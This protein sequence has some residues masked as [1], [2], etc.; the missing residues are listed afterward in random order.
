M[1][2]F[3]FSRWWNNVFQS[4]RT[5]YTPTESVKEFPL[6]NLLTIFWISSHCKNFF[7]GLVGVC[8][9]LSWVLSLCL[10]RNRLHSFLSPCSQPEVANPLNPFVHRIIGACFTVRENCGACSLSEKTLNCPRPSGSS[11]IRRASL[12]AQEGDTSSQFQDY[13]LSHSG[14]SELTGPC[15]LRLPKWEDKWCRSSFSPFWSPANMLALRRTLKRQSCMVDNIL[16]ER[17]RNSWGGG[18]SDGFSIAAGIESVA[19]QR[20]ESRPP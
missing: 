6:I 16:S 2:I 10:N 17:V 19:H 4:G 5:I 1:H 20:L 9:A 13:L 7:S 8:R 15:L 18:M 12:W 11:L 14:L 3:N